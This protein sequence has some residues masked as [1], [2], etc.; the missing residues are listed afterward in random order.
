MHL[1]P[2]L[3]LP[4]D[5]EIVEAD[6]VPEDCALKLDRLLFACIAQSRGATSVPQSSF[7]QL[8]ILLLVLLRVLFLLLLLLMLLLLYFSCRASKIRPLHLLAAAAAAPCDG[9]K[10]IR[11]RTWTMTWIWIQIWRRT[12]IWIRF[13]RGNPSHGHCFSG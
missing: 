6:G 13:W 1:K 2:P 8:L 12:R 5:E 11:I 9:R 4:W 7:S 10:R 3:T